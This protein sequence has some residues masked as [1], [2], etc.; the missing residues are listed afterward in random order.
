MKPHKSKKE[1]HI[2]DEKETSEKEEKTEVTQ[3]EQ[4][5]PQID[6]VTLLKN[7]VTTLKDTLLRKAAE[8][9]NYKKRNENDIANIFKYASENLIKELLPILDDLNR[10]VSSVEKGETKDFETLKTGIF[11]IT[12]KFNSILERA[13]LKDIDCIGKEFDVNTC[14]ALLQVP[15]EDTEPNKV[16]EVVE[17][18]YYL[19]D[20][21]I[22][23]AKVLVSA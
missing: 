5:K 21:I 11:S 4:P 22:R 3:E 1:I 23:H 10:S 16:I 6:E 7:E 12:D 19:K 8:F 14:D 20:K 9:D 2:K 18:G 15:K 17:K 13:G